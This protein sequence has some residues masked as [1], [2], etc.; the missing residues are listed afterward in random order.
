M[1]V[2]VARRIGV[3]KIS[4]DCGYTGEAFD[5]VMRIF[6]CSE[7]WPVKPVTA[8][9]WGGIR[10][11]R[12]THIPTYSHTHKHGGEQPIRCK[13]LMK[14]RLAPRLGQNS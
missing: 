6:G 2:C 1:G 9:R 11:E 14:R 7:G 3:V 12:R 13:D 4:G 8:G 10:S 5:A